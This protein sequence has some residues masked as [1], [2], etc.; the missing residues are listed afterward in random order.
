MYF[1]LSRRPPSPPNP[2][3]HPTETFIQGEHDIADVGGRVNVYKADGTL[4]GPAEQFLTQHVIQQSTGALSIVD[5]RSST[6]RPVHPADLKVSSR[7][8]SLEVSGQRFRMKAYLVLW[9]APQ[10]W[11]EIRL[12]GPLLGLDSKSFLSNLTRN[13]W[14]RWTAALDGFL[15][16]CR[17]AR[18]GADRSL[19][20]RQYLRCLPEA[21]FSTCGLILVVLGRWKS[22][23]GS[24][25]REASASFLRGFLLHFL[26]QEDVEV[27]FCPDMSAIA[28]VGTVHSRASAGVAID[29]GMVYIQQ[30]VDSLGPGQ[31]ALFMHLVR[32]EA[33]DEVASDGVLP[34]HQFL[35]ALYCMCQA[36]LTMQIVGQVAAL[37][38]DIMKEGGGTATP[39]EVEEDSPV[40]PK[41]ARHDVCLMHALSMGSGLGD[42]EQQ[43]WQQAAFVRHYQ[44]VNPSGK[45]LRRLDVRSMNADIML[46]V[47]QVGEDHF[48]KCRHLNI[49]IDGT[50]LGNKDVNFVAIG[51][52]RENGEYRA[53]WCPVQAH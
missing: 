30:F 24:G 18:K 29:Q 31:Q 13:H 33:D 38:D 50:R 17:G 46:R 20:D 14:K 22:S 52:R 28:R 16:V 7:Y 37:L 3:T 9:S 12:M 26:S 8:F 34:V 45:R 6:S 15:P 49:A 32:I 36:S 19:K 41:H 48:S 47:L 25:C 53:S 43:A 21:T 35:L 51:G 5:T 44:M 11:W 40:L 27:Q 10:V 4:V 42:G 39:M 23:R 2:P 1:H